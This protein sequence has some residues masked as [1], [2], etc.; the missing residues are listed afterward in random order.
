MIFS[1]KRTLFALTRVGLS[2]ISFILAL[3]LPNLF[4]S[5]RYGLGN[6]PDPTRV[7]QSFWLGILVMFWHGWPGLVLALPAVLFFTDLRRWRFWTLLALG[8]AIE[9][10]YLWLWLGSGLHWHNLQFGAGAL[11]FSLP[12]SGLSSLIYLLLLQRAQRRNWT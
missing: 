1:R 2:A 9:P 4:L 5:L 10:I 11:K 8:T 12:I 3:A 7:L 6:P